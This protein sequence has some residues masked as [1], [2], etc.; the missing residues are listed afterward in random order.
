MLSPSQNL[1]PK[2][3]LKIPNSGSGRNTKGLSGFYQQINHNTNS[4]FVFDTNL[5]LS[6]LNENSQKMKPKS[7]PKTSNISYENSKRRNISTLNTTKSRYSQ[8]NSIIGNNT[9]KSTNPKI[10]INQRYINDYQQKDKN[11]FYKPQITKSKS[12]LNYSYGKYSNDINFSNLNSTN[13]KEKRNLSYRTIKNNT[14]NRKDNNL[15]FSN[16]NNTIDASPACNLYNSPKKSAKKG[17]KKCNSF[18]AYDYPLTEKNKIQ[19]GNKFRNMTH[20]EFYKNGLGNTLNERDNKSG[21]NFEKC[22]NILS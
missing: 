21:M 14:S 7:R 4:N 3:R 2:K 11:N 10:N 16:P 22:K 20:N 19:T 18:S 9:S 15:Y 13:K 17:H 1:F 5:L 6:I 8:N 12:K